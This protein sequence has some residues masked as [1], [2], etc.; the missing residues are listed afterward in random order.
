MKKLLAMLALTLVSGSSFAGGGGAGQVVN[1]TFNTP[2]VTVHRGETLRLHLEEAFLERGQRW[3]AISQVPGFRL[4]SR[5]DAPMGDHGYLS[6][7]S[8][9][10]YTYAVTSP[11]PGMHVL[12]LSLVNPDLPDEAFLWPLLIK[13]VP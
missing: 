11:T 13:V 1:V 9:I 2:S 4:I 7:L 6:T 3:T 8:N 12:L 10:T 5:D